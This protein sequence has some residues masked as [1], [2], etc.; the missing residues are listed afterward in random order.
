MKRRPAFAVV[1]GASFIAALAGCA[2][3]LRPPEPLPTSVTTEVTASDRSADDLWE[4][5][6]A[7]SVR[8]AATAYEGQLARLVDPFGST[9]GAA[10]AWTWIA[11]RAPTED[12]RREAAGKAVR[13]AQ[14]CEEVAADSPECAYWLGAALG[15]QA[16]QRRSTAI[17]A[18]PRIVKLFESAA[19][20]IPYY[21][22]G[23]PD[24]A[25]ALLYVRAPGFPLG[26]GDPDLAVE[27]ARQAV[28]LA[29]ACAQNLAALGE[30]LEAAGG[31]DGAARAWRRSEAEA[32]AAVER[33]DPDAEEW[34]EEAREALR[35]LAR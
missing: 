2:S 6:T 9:V 12:E 25:L 30:A 11:R 13:A 26:P 17:D 21:E 16:E 33:G 31:H 15:V 7:A 22:S 24:R 23:G 1:L 10:R 3:A 18:L 27:H 28:G 5:R 14:W 32:I 29:P 4:A 35:R 20:R 8:E 34:L 19:L